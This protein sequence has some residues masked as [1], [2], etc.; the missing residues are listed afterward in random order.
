MISEHAG[1][2]LAGC[3]VR[4]RL[5]N[6]PSD[7]LFGNCRNTGGMFTVDSTSNIHES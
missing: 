3:L 2:R 1:A 7:A 6:G 4:V 5:Y